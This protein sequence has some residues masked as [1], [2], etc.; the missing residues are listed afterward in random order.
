M[1]DQK[2]LTLVTLGGGCFEV[3]IQGKD[4]AGN[5]DGVVHYFHLTC[6]ESVPHLPEEFET[7]PRRTRYPVAPRSQ[8]NQYSDIP[9]PMC[10][11][12]TVSLVFSNR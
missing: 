3:H 2:P 11:I 10:C 12:Y 6:S 4:R 5:R 8:K 9:M 1:N 7:T